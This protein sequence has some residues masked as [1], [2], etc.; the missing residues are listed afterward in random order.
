M[1]ALLC[2]LFRGERARPIIRS[3]ASMDEMRINE[4]I[5]LGK[6]VKPFSL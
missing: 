5:N 6:E 4:T 1:N 3:G 2:L